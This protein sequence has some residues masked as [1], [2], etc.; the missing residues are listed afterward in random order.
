MIL[1]VG[2]I[3]FELALEPIP[4]KPMFP[5]RT[6][7]GVRSGADG[8][9]ALIAVSDWREDAGFQKMRAIIIN[10]ERA[11]KEMLRNGYGA[12]EKAVSKAKLAHTIMSG[13][14]AF[15]LYDTY[16]IPLDVT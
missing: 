16:G 11:F 9:L 13:A 12:I 7:L 10:E 15:W 8:M 1:T 2:L 3:G 4:I 6:Q 5:K 14:D